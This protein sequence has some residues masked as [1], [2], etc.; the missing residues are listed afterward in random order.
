MYKRDPLHLCAPLTH[1][2][3]LPCTDL[4]PAKV[5]AMEDYP[6]WA[7]I[8]AIVE[9]H[10]LGTGAEPP[11][12]Y[13]FTRCITKLLLRRTHERVL[14]LHVGPVLGRICKCMHVVRCGHLPGDK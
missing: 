2:A 14:E 4:S 8:N 3:L 9:A 5:N 1:V 7:N 6:L 11:Y 13:A 12:R 10:A